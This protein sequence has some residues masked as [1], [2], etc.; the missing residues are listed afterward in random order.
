MKG[1]YT[2]SQGDRLMVGGINQRTETGV[3]AEFACR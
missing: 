2:G 1:D 3:D